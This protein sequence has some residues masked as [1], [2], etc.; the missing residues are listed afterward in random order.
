MRINY[1]SLFDHIQER[2]AKGIKSIEDYKKQVKTKLLNNKDLLN[3]CKNIIANEADKL[4]S[5]FKT[6]LYSKNEAFTMDYVSFIDVFKNYLRRNFIELLTKLLY[7][8]ENEGI[9]YPLL[10][11]NENIQEF[12]KAEFEKF[13][14]NINLK[15]VEVHFKDKSNPVNFIPGIQIIKIINKINVSKKSGIFA[16]FGNYK[17]LIFLI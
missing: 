11:A 8:F 16:C 4:E 9:L 1:Q 7:T 2:F 6:V 12:N 15:N 5:F 14:T 13:K 3:D 17:I 10:F